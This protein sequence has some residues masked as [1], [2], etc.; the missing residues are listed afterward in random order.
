M[1]CPNCGEE[2]PDTVNACGYCGHR[3]K[4][5]VKPL[6]MQQ[7]NNHEKQAESLPQAQKA[8]KKNTSLSWIIGFLIACLV[9]VLLFYI[10][11]KLFPGMYGL[12]RPKQVF[13]QQVFEPTEIIKPTLRPV[14][15]SAAGPSSAPTVKRR[16]LII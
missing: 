3:L 4:T 13:T 6:N 12:A 5:A 14:F 1:F 10:S 15:T 8:K 7:G 16:T 11:I 2:I 9:I